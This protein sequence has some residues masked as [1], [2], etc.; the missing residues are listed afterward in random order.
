[1]GPIGKAQSTGDLAMGANNGP[2]V[3]NP[4]EGTIFQGTKNDEVAMGPGVIGA[5]QGGG[6]ATVVQ[7]S[8]GTDPALINGLMTKLDELIQAAKT[9]PPIQ[10]GSQTI[11]EIS[12]QQASSNS[13]RQNYNGV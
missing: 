3:T 4:R 1:M 10:I 2:I 6:S 12:N 9:P 8:G 5:A 7:Q 13:F 11:K